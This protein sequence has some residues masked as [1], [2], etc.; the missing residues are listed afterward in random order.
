M[1]C[2]KFKTQ[3][4]KT[5][6]VYDRIYM[7]TLSFALRTGSGSNGHAKKN[8]CG[9]KYTWGSWEDAYENYESDLW[10]D[11][12][13]HI[14]DDDAEPARERGTR[15]VVKCT[16]ANKARRVVGQRKARKVS[17]AR[18]RYSYIRGAPGKNT[19]RGTAKAKSSNSK[20]STPT[21][22]SIPQTSFGAGFEPAVHLG[23]YEEMVTPSFFEQVQALVAKLS[24]PDSATSHDMHELRAKQ[25]MPKAMAS[26]PTMVSIPQTSFGAGFEPAVHLGTYEEMVTPSFFEQ[27]QALVAKLSGPDSAT[28]HDMH[29]LRAKQLMPKAQAKK[30]FS[31]HP[32][33]MTRNGLSV[34]QPM[35]ATRCH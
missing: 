15:Q 30:R 13:L 10:E 19:R 5:R 31:H 3:A 9:G 21:M 28:S 4:Q 35:P 25:L 11:E 23:T 34:R 26:T 17:C 22:V 6:A 2:I 29:E 32:R 12:L 7:A 27:V 20:A 24:G 16:E 18:P 8:G 33:S 1:S 14:Q